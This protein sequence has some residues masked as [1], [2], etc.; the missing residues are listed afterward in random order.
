MTL[1]IRD[2]AP[3]EVAVVRGVLATAF[4]PYRHE[5][6]QGAFDDTVPTLERLTE[7][8][9]EM[10]IAVA[11]RGEAVVGTIGIGRRHHARRAGYLRGMAVLPSCEGQ[12]VGKLLLQSAIDRLI[13]FECTEVYLDTV[14]VLSR[15]AAFYTKFGFEPTGEVTDFFGMQLREYAMKL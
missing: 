1:L 3:G 2:A 7:R 9:A 14:D 4:E 8:M 15:A 5:Y 12:G 6:T 13:Q 10:T 11:V